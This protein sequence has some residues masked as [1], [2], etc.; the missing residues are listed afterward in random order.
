MHRQAHAVNC[1][2]DDGTAI[3]SVAA[4][5]PEEA[6]AA[7]EAKGVRLSDEEDDEVVGDSL[8]EKAE[9]RSSSFR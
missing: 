9:E 4:S 5:S 7:I 6:R 8:K 1:G 2:D 3:I